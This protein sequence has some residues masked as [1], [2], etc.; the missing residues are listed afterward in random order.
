MGD[1]LAGVVLAAGAGTRLAPLTSLRPKALCPVGDRPLVD[2]AI[3]RLGSV[4]ADVAVNAHHRWTDMAT[5]LRGRAH[6]SVEEEPLGTAGALGHLRPWID[7]R[8]V[9]LTNADAW[10]PVDLQPFVDG[11]DGERVRLLCVRDP[12]RG[13]FGDLRYCGAALFPWAEVAMLEDAPAG[14]Y[15]VCWQPRSRSGA[16]DLVVHDGEFVDCGSPADYL[17]ANLLASGGT[18]VVGDGARIGYDAVL[19][20]AVVWP[21]SEVAPYEVLVDAIRAEFLTVLVR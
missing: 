7:E 19:E 18:S 16:L 12:P 13:D 14:L 6:L 10:L 1:S 9:L 2:H 5:H 15:E 20:R 17:E 4:A 3:G 11:W 21:G 8:P